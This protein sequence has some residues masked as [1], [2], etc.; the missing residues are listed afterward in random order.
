MKIL[1]IYIIR[2]F[3]GTFFLSIAIIISIV[4]VFD[5]SEKLDNFLNSKA[6]LKAIVFEYYVNFIPYFINLFSPLFTFIAVIF[7]TSKMAYNTEI[8]AILSSGVSFKRFVRPY[9]ISASLLTII[10]LVLLNFI[11]PYANK[12][13]LRFEEKYINSRYRN[14]DIN[15]HRQIKPGLFLYFESY[16]NFDE[17]GYKFS[18]EEIKNYKLKS[19]INSEIIRW[20]STSQKWIL[21]NYSIRTLFDNGKEKL[22]TGARKD[23][24]LPIDRKEFGTRSSDI[25]T[26]NFF[27]LNA[28]IKDQQMKG[29]SEINFLKVE[30]YQRIALPFATFVLTIIGVSLSSRKV[31]GGIGFQI[32]MGLLLSF[33][34]IL[35]MQVSNTFATAG[36]M[37]PLLAVWIPNIIYMFIASYLFVKAPK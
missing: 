25:Q 32:A 19:K 34:Y 21:E 22:L 37:H 35:F 20:D 14:S 13:R 5:I 33:S 36:N 30:K 8:T 2:K 24:V 23:T 26:M 10:S 6:P 9:M 28:Y 12:G 3:L 7:F 17:I 4:V 27:Q 11:I 1:D 15:I 29:N 16:N 31:R 18:L